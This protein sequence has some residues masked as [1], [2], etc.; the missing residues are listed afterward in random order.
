MSCFAQFPTA[1]TKERSLENVCRSLQKLKRV[2][3]SVGLPVGIKRQSICKSSVSLASKAAG[4]SVVGK[5]C[6]EHPIITERR[7]FSPIR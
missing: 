5:L 1:A 6:F 3:F 4:G 2:I 7:N